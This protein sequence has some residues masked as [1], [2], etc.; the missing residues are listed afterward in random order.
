MFQLVPLR[1]FSSRLH[2]EKRLKRLDADLYEYFSWL[3]HFIMLI[4]KNKHYWIYFLKGAVANF[5]TFFLFLILSFWNLHTICESELRRSFSYKFN[6]FIF[7]FHDFRIKKTPFSH[8]TKKARIWWNFIVHIWFTYENE[9]KAYGR[10]SQ[11]CFFLF[12]SELFSISL[13]VEKKLKSVFFDNYPTSGPYFRKKQGWKLKIQSWA[14]IPHS[15]S[16]VLIRE[17]SL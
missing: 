5:C 11:L 15:S 14:L 17:S 12:K 6:F 10:E 2:T 1:N 3:L 8:P 13:L 4:K 7:V 9:A 16:Y